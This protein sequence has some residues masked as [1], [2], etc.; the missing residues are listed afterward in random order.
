M[1]MVNFLALHFTVLPILSVDPKLD[2]KLNLTI[3]DAQL[4]SFCSFDNK[5][6][7]ILRF[8]SIKNR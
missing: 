3:F 7:I 4:P 2:T 6:D 8:I 1:N 5:E